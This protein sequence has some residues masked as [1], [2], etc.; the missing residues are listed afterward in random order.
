MYGFIEICEVL[1]R[2]CTSQ[3]SDEGKSNVVTVLKYLSTI[4]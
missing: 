4:P 1:C 3:D 2:I